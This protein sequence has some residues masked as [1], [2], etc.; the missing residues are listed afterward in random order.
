MKG[1]RRE[2]ERGRVE[3]WGWEKEGEM[4][5]EKGKAGEEGEKESMCPCAYVLVCVSVCKRSYA[6]GHV[7]ARAT[8]P[9]RERESEGKREQNFLHTH[10]AN[11]SPSYVAIG[12]FFPPVQA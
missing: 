2:R 6:F 7:Y 1:G 5:G 11:I 10:G 4:N 3:E 12:K 8:S 9:G